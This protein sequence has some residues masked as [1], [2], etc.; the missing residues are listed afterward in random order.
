ML[1]V[2]VC[3]PSVI[4]FPLCSLWCFRIEEYVDMLKSDVG[5]LVIYIEVNVL[6]MVN[7]KYNVVIPVLQFNEVR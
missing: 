1:A 4:F 5:K 3:S 6:Y 7:I 2:V